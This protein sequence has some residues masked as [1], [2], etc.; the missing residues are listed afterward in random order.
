M[1]TM[2]A[3][4]SSSSY[5]LRDELARYCLPQ[6]SRDPNRKL[7]WMNSICILFLIIGIFGTPSATIPVKEAPPVEEAIPAILESFPPPPVTTENQT[8]NQNEQQKTEAPQ[9]VVVTPEAPNINFSVPTI[10]NLVAPS[11]LAQ[12][13]PL[14]PMQPPAPLKTLPM[15]LNNTGSGGARPAPPYPKIAQDQGEQG[16]V[17]L[18]MQ[19]DEAGNL[20]SVEVKQSSG[21]P[22]LDRS[23]MDFVRRHWTVSPG[24]SNRLFQATI[25]YQL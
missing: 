22:V 10:G 24:G 11:A 4:R 15:T 21:F 12:A 1:K 2:D 8:E 16:R 17:T 18:L 23:A 20:L 5:E 3:S 6:A 25:T 9:V 7:A 19:A 14:R 13:P